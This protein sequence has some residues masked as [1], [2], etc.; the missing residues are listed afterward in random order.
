[1]D[2]E[3]A[4]D[5]VRQY[6]NVVMPYM[7]EKARIYLYGSYSK[8]YQHAGS[9][10]DVAVVVP[11]IGADWLKLSQR[12]WRDVDKVNVLIEPVLLED[13]HQSPLYEDVMQTG[14]AV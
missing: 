6:K 2:K 9:D 3:A 11:S 12:L 8:G 7:G 5:I 10:I 13:C 4:L 1:M 14:V